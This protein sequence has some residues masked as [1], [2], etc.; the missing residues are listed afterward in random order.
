MSVAAIHTAGVNWA[1]VAAIAGSVAA[2]M[3]IIIG[4]F[5]KLISSQITTAID[6][7]RIEVVN[8]LDTRL[9]AA[10]TSLRDIQANVRRR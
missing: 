7:F 3:S 8:K 5:A 1:S 4:L 6:K 10:E 2:I 9:T